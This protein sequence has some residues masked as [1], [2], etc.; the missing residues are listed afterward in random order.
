VLDKLEL[1]G[2][3]AQTKVKCRVETPFQIEGMN[4]MGLPGVELH[5]LLGYTVLAK[6]RM[7]LD[8]TRDRMKWT[9]LDFEPPPPLPL[10]NKATTGGLDALAGVMKILSFF[11]GIKPAPPPQP[12][13][14][15]GFEV[16][17]KDGKLLVGRVLPDS[18]AADAG[19]K[20][21][22]V[23]RKLDGKEVDT[24]DGLLAEAS[25]HV[26]GRTVRLSVERGRDEEPRV[27]IV[28]VGKG[29]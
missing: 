24:L 4:S 26:V 17:E 5:G 28:R 22:D 8:F 9:P 14:F 13:G 12:R 21:G 7:E 11:A 6:Y 27:L 15:F 10:G 25:K 29:F 3:L 19:L 1:E 23:V 18:P 20:A 2:G 16:D